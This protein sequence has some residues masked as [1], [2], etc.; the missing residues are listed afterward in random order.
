M[1]AGWLTTVARSVAVWQDGLRLF[2][3]ERVA[4]FY[5]IFYI[6][7]GIALRQVR[8]YR[9]GRQVEYRGNFLV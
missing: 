9:A 4:Q 5:F 6:Q 7:F 1:R 3:F 2:I 8:P